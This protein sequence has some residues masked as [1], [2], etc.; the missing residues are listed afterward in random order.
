[1]MPTTHGHPPPF[2]P[3]LHYTISEDYHFSSSVVLL[4]VLV[5]P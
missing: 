4:V 3:L 5:M 1:M 2:R